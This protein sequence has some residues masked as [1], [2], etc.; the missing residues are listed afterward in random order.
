MDSCL[1]FLFFVL[2]CSV[3]LVDKIN[4]RSCVSPPAMTRQTPVGGML[5][6]SS[7]LA[8]SSLLSASSATCMSYHHLEY[9]P[10]L[11][12]VHANLLFMQIQ[13]NLYIK[14]AQGPKKAVFID[15]WSLLCSF[16]SLYVD[17]S[18]DCIIN[19]DSFI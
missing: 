16:E 19:S 4:V 15:R 17:L 9:L 6:L 7:M 5:L 3:F 2:F 14:T 10:L 8:S 11:F 12:V 1:G 13:S 18:S